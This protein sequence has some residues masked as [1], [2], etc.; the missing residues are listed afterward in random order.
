MRVD[1][2]EERERRER[3][4]RVVSVSR[5]RDEKNMVVDKVKLIPY[6]S[7]TS[8]GEKVSREKIEQ[9]MREKRTNGKRER[10]ERRGS[11]KMMCGKNV[12]CCSLRCQGEKGENLCVR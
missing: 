4:R 12:F 3:E 9:K 2:R 11:H 7:Y 6:T 8:R 10:R 5:K 1:E